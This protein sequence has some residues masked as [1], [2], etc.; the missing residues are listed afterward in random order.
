MGNHDTISLYNKFLKICY[1]HW[2]LVGIL[3]KQQQQQENNEIQ[4]IMNTH[5]LLFFFYL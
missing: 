2:T 3:K 4:T 1:Q 5:W